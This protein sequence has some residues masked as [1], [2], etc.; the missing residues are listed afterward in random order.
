MVIDEVMG[1]KDEVL[2]SPPEAQR[3]QQF[4]ES[5][6]RLDY[7]AGTWKASAE[8]LPDDRHRIGPRSSEEDLGRQHQPWVACPP[9]RKVSSMMAMPRQ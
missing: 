7:L 5:L 3:P 1:E 4:P 9:P 6:G 8:F 2:H